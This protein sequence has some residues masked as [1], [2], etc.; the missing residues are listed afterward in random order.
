MFV[1]KPEITC[2]QVDPSR[3]GTLPLLYL[4]LAI[5]VAYFINS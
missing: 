4:C 1:A 3:S 5:K 2:K